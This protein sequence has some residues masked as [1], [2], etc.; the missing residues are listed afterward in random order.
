[1]PAHRVVHVPDVDDRARRADA[2]GGI[3]P[4][5]RRLVERGVRFVLVYLSDYGEWDS[6]TQLR[7]LHARSSARVDRPIAGLLKDLKR[8]G[9]DNDVSVV[10]CTEFGR[11]PGLE[12]RNG[13]SA[14]AT[15]TSSSRE[16]ALLV[17]NRSIRTENGKHV[18]Y[19]P[20]PQIG[21]RPVTV[22]VGDS[23]ET[24]TVI[25]SGLNEGEDYITDPPTTA[26]ANNPAAFRGIFGGGQR[27]GE[28]AVRRTGLLDDDLAV[29]LADGRWNLSDVLVDERFDR[30]RK[31]THRTG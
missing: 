23:D 20:A 24:N 17:P 29:T 26:A 12:V 2:A 7:D 3:R 13:M 18:V 4:V 9:L 21:L 19:I 8:R 15:I 28:R 30:I 1:M 27:V 25:T 22:Q 5:E 31:Q 14:T 10:C 6:H 11:T 16:N